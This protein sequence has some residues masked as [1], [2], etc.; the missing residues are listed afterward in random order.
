LPGQNGANLYRDFSIYIFTNQQANYQIKIDNFTVESGSVS[1]LKRIDQHSDY[2]KADIYVLVENLTGGVRDFSFDDIR[3]VD[4]P[5]SSSQPDESENNQRSIPD[6]I[7][8]YVEMSQGE[9]NLFIAKRVIADIASVIAG[10]IVGIQI[11][12]LKA[13]FRGIERAL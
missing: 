2:S 8:P 3:L 10:I 11:A 5:W 13:D 12:A 6:I 9:F 7:K 4:N 1:W